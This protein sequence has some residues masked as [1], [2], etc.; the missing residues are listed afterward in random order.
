MQDINVGSNNRT[1]H[2][3][4]VRHNLLWVVLTH[5][6]MEVIAKNRDAHTHT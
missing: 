6:A 3:T 4:G 5:N 1:W 2:S